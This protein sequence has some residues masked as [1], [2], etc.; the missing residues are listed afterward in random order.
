MLLSGTL[1]V[2]LVS[3]YT[4]SADEYY[5]TYPLIQ[6]DFGVALSRTVN[7][8]S[9]T[10]TQLFISSVMGWGKDGD[11]VTTMTILIQSA[12]YVQ[13]QMDDLNL[14]SAPSGLTVSGFETVSSDCLVASSFTWYAP[15]SSPSL[16]CIPLFTARFIHCLTHCR[17][18]CSHDQRSN[19]Y[20]ND[21]RC[22]SG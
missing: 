4:M 9:T 8:L 14:I 17:S 11:D 6:Q 1:F 3:P 7:V 10:N 2:E 21:S 5:R 18:P 20:D 13:L 16:S 12:D 22:V 19:F 15:I